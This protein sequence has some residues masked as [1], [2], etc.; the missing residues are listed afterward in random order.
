MR[1][2]CSVRSVRPIQMMQRERRLT[3]E[4]E[5]SDFLSGCG[6]GGSKDGCESVGPSFN[7]LRCG[8]LAQVDGEHQP[9]RV[10]NLAERL[11]VGLLAHGRSLKSSAKGRS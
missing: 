2:R 5:E 11:E 4:F 7:R 9:H 3:C 8:R 1:S 6:R 10:Q